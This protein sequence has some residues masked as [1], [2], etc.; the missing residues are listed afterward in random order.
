MPCKS[1]I[2]EAFLFCTNRLRQEKR[3][4]ARRYDEAIC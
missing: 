1:M 3:V 2:Y 4:I